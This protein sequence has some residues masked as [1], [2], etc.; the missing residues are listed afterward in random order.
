MAEAPSPKPR[1]SRRIR[2]LGIFAILL[3]VLIVVAPLIIANTGLRDRVINA[4]LASPSVTASSQSASFGWFS[5]LAI[6]GL[7][8]TSTNQHI[9]IQ[10]ENITAEQSPW[11]LLASSPELGTIKL[12]K[13]QIRLEL[14][15][16]LKIEEQRRLEP[17]F[18]AVVTD[19]ALTV[20]LPALDE[21]ALD[22]DG[23]NVTFRVEKSDEGRLLTLD[24]VVIFDR[25]ELSPK[26]G[27]TLLQLIDPT[28]GD[29][30][31][32][33]GQVS[34][35]LEKLRIPIGIPRDQQAQRVEVEGKLAL[36]HVSTEVNSSLGQALVHLVAD[37]NG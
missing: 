4:I 18:T 19:A 10:V 20:R 9:D 22:V 3:V 23:I 34:L 1:W 31:Q 36:H 6:H 13:P 26:L 17:T 33:A 28:L 30:P 25:R 14:P 11:Q 32:V 12:N 27:K 5:P 37:M 29:A 24:P 2:I 21:P 15:L 35:S 8:L 7:Q 16:D